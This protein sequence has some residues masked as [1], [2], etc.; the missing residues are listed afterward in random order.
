M[1]EKHVLLF[2]HVLR[3]IFERGGDFKILFKVGTALFK[4]DLP[5]INTVLRN[6]LERSDKHLKNLISSNNIKPEEKTIN[7]LNKLLAWY[8]G[9]SEYMMAFESL[10]R[11]SEKQ[12]LNIEHW[13]TYG[14][15]LIKL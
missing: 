1:L 12:F 13:I 2:Y 4:S 14:F 5:N 8:F 3:K 10:D 6:F 7:N 9:R 11:S 15:D